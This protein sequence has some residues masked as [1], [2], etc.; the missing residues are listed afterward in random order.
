MEKVKSTSDFAMCAKKILKQ[1]DVFCFPESDLNPDIL[2]REQA[3][4]RACLSQGHAGH[5]PQGHIFREP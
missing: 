1:L 3:V 4:S 5:V 2:H